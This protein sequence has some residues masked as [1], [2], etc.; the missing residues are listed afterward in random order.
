MRDHIN[1]KLVIEGNGMQQQTVLLLEIDSRSYLTHE[2]EIN[3]INK[4]ITNVNN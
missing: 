2:Y 3:N 1:G 4:I